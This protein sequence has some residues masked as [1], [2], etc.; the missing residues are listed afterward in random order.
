MDIF[1]KL[2]WF[3]KKEKKRY[4]IGIT[5]LAMTSLAN[6]IPPRVLGVMADELDK[7]HIT[8]LLYTSDAADDA[9]R[10]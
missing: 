3:F 8:C 7:N 6:L 5:L 9:P 4:V 10:V 1:K 2:S